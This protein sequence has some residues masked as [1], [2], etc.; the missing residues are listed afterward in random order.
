MNEDK[1]KDLTPDEKLDL[2]LVEPA[3]VKLRLGNLESVAGDIAA[4]KA[5]IATANAR[6]SALEAI[7]EDRSRETRPQLDRIHKELADLR[8]EVGEL[9]QGQER[10]ESRLERINQQLE[11]VTLDLMEMR[12]KTRGLDKCVTQLERQSAA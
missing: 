2:I 4:L 10:I 7:A 11:I 12:G 8:R 6:L 1:T 9:K 5:G 3:S